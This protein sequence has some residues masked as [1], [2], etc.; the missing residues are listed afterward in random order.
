MAYERRRLRN[1]YDKLTADGNIDDVNIEILLDSAGKFSLSC[2]SFANFNKLH[3]CLR[4]LKKHERSDR[5]ILR[6][7]GHQ[8]VTTLNCLSNILVVVNICVGSVK[9]MLL[10]TCDC[11]FC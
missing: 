6:H 10:Y 4:F 7:N 2:G 11:S 1:I 3:V 8:E 9:Q 5:T